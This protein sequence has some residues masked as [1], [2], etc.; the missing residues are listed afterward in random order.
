M[1][2]AYLTDRHTG[3]IR[4]CLL[5]LLFLFSAPILRSEEVRKLNLPTRDLLYDAETQRIYASVPDG[6]GDIG[7]SITAIDPATRAIGPSVPVGSDPGKLA[8]S[9]DGQYLYVA[10]DGESKINRI[11]LATLTPGTPYSIAT[12]SIQYTV[13]DLEALPGNPNAVVAVRREKSTRGTRAVVVYENGVARWNTSGGSS[14][15]EFGSSPD[16]LYGFDNVVGSS[17]TTNYSFYRMRVG[18]SG[19]RIVDVSRE[20]IRQAPTDFRHADGRLYT[21]QGKIIDPEARIVIGTLA[22]ASG[23]VLPDPEKRRVYHLSGSGAATKLLAYDLD[24][25]ILVGSLNLPDAMGSTGS[26]I[27]WGEDGLAFRTSQNQVFLI[28]TPLVP[29]SNSA[30]DLSVSVADSP[31]PAQVGS[32]MAY[33][34]TVTNHGPSAVAGVAVEGALDPAFKYV[35]SEAPQG[36]CSEAGGRVRCALG[37]LDV[38]ASATVR[39]SVQV[40][41]PGWIVQPFQAVSLLSD[42][43]KGNNT[44]S[45]ATE[46]R[47]PAGSAMNRYSLPTNDLLYD[48]KRRRLYASIPSR[49][50]EIGD[51]VVS[52]DPS[53]GALDWQL[54]VGKEPNKL[55]LSDDSRYLYVGVDGE[56]AVRR[57]DL[58]G[59]AADLRFALGVTASST[60][61]V[62]HDLEVLPGNPNAVA[63]S[64]SPLGGIVVYDGGIPRPKV[65]GPLKS[66]T[67]SYV[68]TQNF[69]IEFSPTASRLYATDRTY[70]NRMAVDAT[71][72][73]PEAPALDSKLH[74]NLAEFK[75][76][77]KYLYSPNGRVF[78][79][80][81]LREVEGYVPPVTELYP[82]GSVTPP[83]R[84]AEPDPA[85]G[86]DFFVTTLTNGTSVH[87]YDRGTTRWLGTIPLPGVA[88]IPTHLLRWGL[89]GLALRLNDSSL[90]LARTPLTGGDHTSDLSLRIADSPEPARVG[91]P[92][93]Y[94]F[95]VTNH[96]P[97]AVANS[98]LSTAVPQGSAFVSATADRGECAVT[99]GAVQCQLGDLPPQATAV[100]TLAVTPAQAGTLIVAG[101]VS[102][103]M[104]D[105]VAVNNVDTE[106][107]LVEAEESPHSVRILT[108]PTN[109]LAADPVRGVLY[110]TTPVRAGVRGNSIAVIEPATGEIGPFYPIGNVPHQLA[111]SGGGE[112]AY[113]YQT[114]IE[115]IA[116]L[117]LRQGITDL[118]FPI[119]N[120]PRQETYDVSDLEVPPGHPGGVAAVLQNTGGYDD[121]RIAL[122]DNGV[123]RPNVLKS[124]YSANVIE[125]NEAGT[126]LY[127]YNNVSTGMDFIRMNVDA[128]GVTFVDNARSFDLNLI[129]VLYADMKQA[130]G[131]IYT[132]NGH[133]ID[134]ETRQKVATC[135]LPSPEGWRQPNN[136][137]I[138]NLVYPDPAAH[139]IF[140]LVHEGG[141]YKVLAF[142]AKTY[143]RVGEM[144]VPGVKGIP[145]DLT[146]WGADGLAFRT[147]ADQVFLIRTPLIPSGPGADLGIAQA[148]APQP[149]TVGEDLTFTSTLTN[150]GPSAAR[151]VAFANTLPAEMAF[152][153]A[154]ATLGTCSESSG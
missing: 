4:N 88:G 126:R 144:P 148:Q 81:A 84:R 59:P 41:S 67:T 10:L 142:D 3:R 50:A 6:V 16:R 29:S 83:F 55:A 99:G 90:L 146:R 149:A 24:T 61:Y 12:G 7:N 71:G 143:L 123:E 129:G 115:S 151:S 98:T 77:G 1:T 100:V 95:T 120:A 64:R 22:G 94:R 57:I 9:S 119:G 154:R 116:R 106:A 104:P 107:T 69:E 68:S 102:S 101:S 79:P 27:R 58:E 36:S 74:L 47:F 49:A 135:V 125:F 17:P 89:D 31:D 141:T 80:E 21:T 139:R 76:D 38:G 133:V 20:L 23:P 137:Y 153:S 37:T 87:A 44:D 52:L 8:R 26:L 54:S 131:L 152:V 97:A 117:D 138:P 78:D 85:G 28:R 121:D 124:I 114:G 13:L 56:G 108:L 39:V 130:N 127:S 91:T 93:P 72:V 43:R 134:P 14:V 75:F 53:T 65:A 18:A 34:V 35:A 111:I 112:Y 33:A 66:D 32:A 2:I 70:L 122:Y 110:A 103:A 46:V 140:F 82:W 5:L 60:P 109:D 118:R 40:Q 105:S 96:G 11:S 86:R 15:I 62:A 42:P 113:T 147:S 63:V 128:S 145:S 19:V 51:R 48:G 25:L 30:A 73:T 92:L 136:S 132:S 45:E 150:H